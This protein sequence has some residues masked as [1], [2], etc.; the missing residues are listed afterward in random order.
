MRMIGYSGTIREAKR[1]ARALLPVLLL[2]ALRAQAEV[3][4]G[5][6]ALE[7]RARSSADGSGYS[8]LG[9]WFGE[10]RQFACANDAF[11]SSLRLNPKSARVNY[12]LAVSLYAAGEKEQA[13]RPL[14]RS[15][16]LDPR[17]VQPRSLHAT[18]LEELGRRREAKEEWQAILKIVP[19]SIEA[20]DGLS[21]ILI[22]EHEY[23]AAIELLRN[24]PPDEDL[25]LNLAS[26]YGELGMFAGAEATV[27]RE[28]NHTP[29]SLRLT[30]ALATVYV[31]QHRYQDAAVLLR[32]SVQQYPADTD[33]AIQ[34]LSILVLTND[35]ATARPLGRKLL[36]AKP[37]SFD[38][39]S[40]NGI[41]ERQAEEYA[42]AL[43]HLAEAVALEP[44][45]Y[46]AR[47]NLGATLAQLNRPA[48][49]KAQLE[50]AIAL[51]SS[52][53][54]AHF[55]L[56]AVLRS[57]QDT[58]GAQR[59]LATYERLKRDS[60]AQAE[61]QSKSEQGH[62]KFVAG[63][64][65]Q[66]AELYREAI[67]A[68]PENALLRYHLATALDRMGDFQGEQSA[69]NAAVKIDPTFA[70][71]Q[72]QLGFLA[73]RNGDPAT[74][75]I[76]FRA[77]VTSAPAFTAAWINLAATLAAESRFTEAKQAAATALRLEP[78]NPQASELDRRLAAAAPR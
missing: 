21:K 67:A 77:A 72:N 74:A 1:T 76:H 40:M 25:A 36:A 11:R 24:A 17:V 22:A 26:A 5:S 14:A 63:D 58:E 8:D 9:T 37:H 43:D 59:E 57:A 47:Y 44:D 16:D 69:L 33:A 65:A 34:Y 27:N 23:G 53:P 10:H 18:I 41:L 20:L 3:C 49:A 75:E 70:L 46:T 62:Q 50:R 15:V 55:Q 64:A 7:A 68:T 19:S 31:H 66:A 56:A 29:E 60:A 61:A 78:K 38:V 28:R 51:D 52:H 42:A 4:K 45:D 2:T 71:A 35:A 48:E 54:E 6:A 13:L 32:Q 73:S 12:F 39:L 30:R